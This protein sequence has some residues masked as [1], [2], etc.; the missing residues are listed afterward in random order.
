MRSSTVVSLSRAGVSDPWHGGF[1]AA[2]HSGDC[3]H[4]RVIRR[5]RRR[6]C[7]R[8]TRPPRPASRPPERP[9]GSPVTRCRLTRCRVTRRGRS[10]AAEPVRYR[11][12]AS[13]RGLA[14]GAP[15]A[16][17]GTAASAPLGS[18]PWPATA[19]AGPAAD[20]PFANWPVIR[21]CPAVGRPRRLPDQGDGAVPCSVTAS[22]SHTRVIS[23][24][25]GLAPSRTRMPCRSASRATANRP[26][27][28][29]TETSMTGGLSSRMF[30][31]VSRGL[32]YAD[33]AVA[34]LDQHAPAGYFL[35]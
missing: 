13:L 15:G 5:S 31:S 32:G 1:R 22:G 18:A 14:R 26:M 16:G 17:I 2:N 12:V 19:E 10:R 3:G 25:G 8:P 34:H 28:R 7:F 24:R 30:I 23:P 35:A 21:T 9:P 29:D 11:R 6:V 27:C 20:Q 4:A 33:P